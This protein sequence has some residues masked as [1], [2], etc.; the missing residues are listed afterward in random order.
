MYLYKALVRGLYTDTSLNL[1]QMC[2]LAHW[3]ATSIQKTVHVTQRHSYLHQSR[4][5]DSATANVTHR[6]S[7]LHQTHSRDMEGAAKAEGATCLA[8]ETLSLSCC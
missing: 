4:H 7:Y 3:A 8:A 1:Y 5:R 6:H 2:A